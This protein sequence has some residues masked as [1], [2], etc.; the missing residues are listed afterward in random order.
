MEHGSKIFIAGHTGLVGSYLCN[1][2]EK[3]GYWNL[4][5]CPSSELDLRRQG[6]VDAFFSRERPEYVFMAAA[7]K[8]GVAEYG[9]RPVEFFSDNMLMEI[10]ILSA[11]CRYKVKKMVLAG[12]SCVYPESTGQVIGETCFPGGWVQKATEPYALAKAAGLKLA[13]YYNS[14]YGTSYVTAVLSNIYGITDNAHMDTTSVMP[15]LIQRFKKAAAEQGSEVAVWRD[16]SNKREFLHAGDCAEALIRIMESGINTGWVNVGFGEMVSIRELAGL[17]AQAVNYKGDIVFDH[18][19]PN[20]SKRSVLDISKLRGL[21]WQPS[22]S[23]EAGIRE[24]ADTI[25]F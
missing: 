13:E 10:N 24:L 1:S 15:A 5:T 11:A 7:V 12:A 25:P 3:K 4:L 19:K 20:G 23:L 6:E 8:A 17:V 9:K 22:V 16:G 18:T 21:D 2:L 14:E